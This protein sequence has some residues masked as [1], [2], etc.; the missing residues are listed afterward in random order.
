MF[1]CYRI[2]LYHNFDVSI[3]VITIHCSD[4]DV[5]EA[6]FF[7]TFEADG[8]PDSAAGQ[9]RTEVPAELI[10]GFSYIDAIRI[11]KVRFATCGSP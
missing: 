5:G 3:M 6:G 4:V 7:N 8:S 10:L 9:D 1:F 11:P 2:Q